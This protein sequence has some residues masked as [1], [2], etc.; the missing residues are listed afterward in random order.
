MAKQYKCSAP[1][2]DQFLKAIRAQINLPAT[3]AEPVGESR[4][5]QLDSRLNISR[6]L[7]GKITRSLGK[8]CQK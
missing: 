3:N 2:H 4:H 1:L 7:I 8:Y 5:K 6:K